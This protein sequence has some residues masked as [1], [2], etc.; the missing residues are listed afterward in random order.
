MARK[1]AY[2]YLQNFRF[3][4][5]EVDGGAGAFPFPTAGFNNVTLPNITIEAA[6]HRTGISP[7]PKKQGGIMAV[8]DITMTRGIAL[9]DTQFFDWIQKYRNKQPYRTDL[10]ICVYN[11]E[12]NGENPDD[13]PSRVLKLKECIPTSVKAMG[14]LDAS[15][16]DINIGEI[17]CACE[18]YDLD[19]PAAS[20]LGMTL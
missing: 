2:D 15:A 7:L 5:I 3:R 20:E 4:V 9:G 6:E 14:D 17:T 18:D 8:E 10:M 13:Q 12:I 16:S 1:T 19:A 11:Q